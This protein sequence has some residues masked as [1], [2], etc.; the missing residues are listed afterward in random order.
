MSELNKRFV[1]AH[2]SRMNNTTKRLLLHLRNGNF[3][4]ALSEDGM[5]NV[6]K[7]FSD[8]A[9][10]LRSSE[11]SEVIIYHSSKSTSAGEPSWFA[12]QYT[13]R[14]DKGNAAVQPALYVVGE[15]EKSLH[16]IYPES[17][18]IPQVL[19]TDAEVNWQQ[20]EAEAAK[21]EIARLN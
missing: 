12:V 10:S 7:S 8:L 15:A 11:T 5:R 4:H 3:A 20:L 21:A 14:A 17:S 19:L 18:R 1:E 16:E 9:R 13:L 2:S 6:S